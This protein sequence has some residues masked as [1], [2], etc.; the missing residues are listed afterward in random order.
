LY[1]CESSEKVYSIY[2]QHFFFHWYLSVAY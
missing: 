2:F 1:L